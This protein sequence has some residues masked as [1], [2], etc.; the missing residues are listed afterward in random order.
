MFPTINNMMNLFKLIKDLLNKY[1]KNA[2]IEILAYADFDLQGGKFLLADHL[3]AT[4][5]LNEIDDFI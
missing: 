3:D 2:K 4:D 1:Q 5:D